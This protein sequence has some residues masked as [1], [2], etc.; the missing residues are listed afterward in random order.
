MAYYCSKTTIKWETWAAPFSESKGFEPGAWWTNRDHLIKDN[1]LQVYW[2][3]CVNTVYCIPCSRWYNTSATSVL[4]KQERSFPVSV[5][6][7][8]HH[9][10]LQKSHAVHKCSTTNLYVHMAAIPITMYIW[11]ALCTITN[12]PVWHL[13]SIGQIAWKLKRK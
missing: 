4:K 13:D 8:I 6:I 12:M 3:N 5:T 7:L 10:S 2:M 9:T 11:M 1:L